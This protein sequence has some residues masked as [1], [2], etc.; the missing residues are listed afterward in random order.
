MVIHLKCVHHYDSTCTHSDDFT[1]LS[2]GQIICSLAIE[3]PGCKDE[4]FS[5]KQISSRDIVLFLKMCD[6]CMHVYSLAIS[7]RMAN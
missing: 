7:V 1:T 4:P 2:F 6:V 3:S 5:N